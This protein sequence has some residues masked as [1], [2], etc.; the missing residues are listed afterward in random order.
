M[1]FI[2]LNIPKSI[3]DSLSHLGFSEMTP[4]QEAVIPVAMTGRDILGSAQTGTGKTAAFA[5]PALNFLLNN[6]DKTVLV[7]LPTRE[8]ATQVLGEFQKMMG[9]NKIPTALLI[10]GDSIEKQ[11]RQIKLMPRV[12]VGTPGRINDHLEHRVLNLKN[13]EFLVLDETDR[14]LD[15]GFAKQLDRIIDQLPKKRQTLMLSATF[16]QNILSLAGKY[17]DDPERI[18]VGEQNN[19]AENITQQLVQIKDEKKY[20]KLVELLDGRAGSI[21]VF[22]KTKYGAERLAK[23]LAFIKFQATALH[24]GMPQS[25]RDRVVREFRNKEIKI[26]VATDVAAR[27]LDISHIE[28]VINYDMPQQAEDYIHR[29]GRTARAGASGTAINLLSRQDYDLW[30]D[31]CKLLKTPCTLP[32]PVKQDKPAKDSSKSSDKNRKPRTRKSSGFGRNRPKK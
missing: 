1:N 18:S 16:P 2:K 30:R 17:L 13:A 5:V 3:L 12:I 31:I 14:M 15:M 11:K 6:K 23:K 26:L 29:I 19:V 32:E 4:I 25:K 8:L 27:G 7:L 9:S 24:G 28:T 21:L 22:A 20:D 10:G